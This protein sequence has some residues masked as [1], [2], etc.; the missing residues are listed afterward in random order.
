MKNKM[1][2]QIT[3]NNNQN[4]IK[5]KNTNSTN[6][7]T[8]FMNDNNYQFISSSKSILTNKQKFINSINK[9]IKVMSERDNFELKSVNGRLENR[10]HINVIDNIVRFNFKY[11]GKI[12]ILPNQ[13]TNKLKNGSLRVSEY[14]MCENN[15][16]KYIDVLNSWRD[17]FN[18]MD[19]N[20][21]FFNQ[22]S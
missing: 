6:L 12:V 7:I 13:S 8:Q 22:L 3:I 9:E 10:F 1:K 19:E 20:D 15:I 16:E 18:M 17:V 2:N 5:M 21:E 4:Q 11:K 14:L